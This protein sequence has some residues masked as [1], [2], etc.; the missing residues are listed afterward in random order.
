MC[1]L[2]SDCIDALVL[3]LF[4]FYK[5]IPNENLVYSLCEMAYCILK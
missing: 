4:G 3:T 2:V 5:N 1:E